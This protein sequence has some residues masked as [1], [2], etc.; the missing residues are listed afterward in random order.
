MSQTHIVQLSFADDLQLFS[1]GDIDSTTLMYECFQQF[2]K[3]SGLLANQAKS[4]VYFG[5]VSEEIQQKILQH[6]GFSKGDLPFRYLGVPLSSKKL[7]ISQCQPLI[8]KIMG[9]INT[10][11][12][13]FLS[14]AGR[15]QLVNSVL[16][17]MQGFWS[18]IFLMPK[19]VLKKI[20]SMCKRFL[21]NGDKE[22]KGKALIVWET[23][24]WPKAAGGLN[25]TDMY[26]W[27]KAAIL[28]HMWNLCKKKDKLWIVWVH[29]FYLKGR[30]PWEVDIKQASWMVKKILKAGQWLTERG[31]Q[32]T[33]I[34]EETNFSIKKMYQ[35]LKGEYNKVPWRRLTCNNLDSPKW[36]FALYVAIHRRLYTKDRLSNWGI[37]RDD[38]C[39]LCKAEVETHQHLFFS[40][41][42]SKQIWHKMLNWLLITR[43]CEG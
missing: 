23:L 22:G 21:W 30:D 3:V 35:V 40:C 36:V 8:D 11:T 5:G 39:A 1:R 12:T 19:K 4:C 2:S 42:F 10:W 18:Q 24:C 16:S 37:I 17:A 26:V 32:V 13:K 38:V 9:R 43:G 6:T 34:M 33:E 7:S 41:N 15:L 28:K 25:I 14:Y 31:L 29:T 27:N 20:E